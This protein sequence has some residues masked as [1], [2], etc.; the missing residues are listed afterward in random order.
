MRREKDLGTPLGLETEETLQRGD[1]VF[2]PGHVGIMRDGTML[3]H[4]SAHHML[5]VSEPLH[6]VRDRILAKTSQPI[7]AVKRL[8]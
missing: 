5:V 7:A 4:A 1:L 6:A 2:W 8:M 3:L